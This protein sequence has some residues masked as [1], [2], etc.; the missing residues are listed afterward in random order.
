MGSNLQLCLLFL[1]STLRYTSAIRCDVTLPQKSS[2]DCKIVRKAAL[3]ENKKTWTLKHDPDVYGFARLN[4]TPAQLAAIVFK[5]P[6]TRHYTTAYTQTLKTNEK[7]L[8]KY[9]NQTFGQPI[10]D[11]SE[12]LA[13]SEYFQ[14]VLE[15][16]VGEYATLASR[17]EAFINDKTKWI[18]DKYFT[19]QRLAGTNPMSLQRV[20]VHERDAAVGLDWNK[21]K[22]TLNPKFDWD[23]AVQAVLSKGYSLKK[24]V[25]QGRIYALRYELCD[26]LARSPDLTDKD[27]QREMWNF[28]SPI[29]LFASKPISRGKSELLPVAIQMDF[30]PDSAVYTPNDGDNWMM[31][32]FNVQVT[33]IGYAQIVEHLARVHFMVEPFCVILKRTLSKQHPLNQILRFHCRELTVPN[34]FGV[35][36]LVNE[37]GLT[38][39]LF[40]YGNKGSFRM[41]KDTYPLSTW[42]ITDYRGNIKKRGLDDERLL[43]FFP[44]RDDGYI[45]LEVIEQMVKDYITMYYENDKDVKEDTELQDYV[46]ELSLDGTGPNGG[47]GRIQG[48]PKSIST[49]RELYEILSRFLSHVTIYHAAVNYVVVD[50]G[51][52]I[53][54]Q[55]TKLYNDS[56]VEVGEFSVYRLPN[57]VTTAIQSSAFNTL[58]IFRLD[59]LFDYGNFL[60][61]TDA[62][63]LVNHYYSKLMLVVQPKLQSLNRKRKDRGDLTY[64]YFIPKWLPNGIQT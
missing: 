22:E 54:N 62:V 59:R 37:N 49:R 23:A 9:I 21:L 15:P 63:N 57:R 26:G 14:T 39:K 13:M 34:T 38:D 36:N 52:Y 47:I 43:P 17:H 41:L 31:A 32:K 6:F 46:N 24:A 4:M 25:D 51:Q 27:P 10:N 45:I 3:A 11:F 44:F 58:G 29:A 61:D 56:R 5:D 53:P 2:P 28:F 55:P 42:E 12:Y 20:T 35:P 18:S 30:K 16:L 7:V 8:T 19:Q 50:Y 1:I 33:D 64:P 60:E 40:A 48:F